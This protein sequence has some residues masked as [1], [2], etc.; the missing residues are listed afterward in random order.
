MGHFPGTAL[1][2]PREQVKVPEDWVR[3]ILTTSR[4]VTEFPALLG[5]GGETPWAGLPIRITAVVHLQILAWK[6]E[7]VRRTL[8]A[9]NIDLHR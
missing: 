8:T 2:I 3:T 7:G 5:V 1:L 4:D 9:L 6:S